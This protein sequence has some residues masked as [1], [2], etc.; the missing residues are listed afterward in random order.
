MKKQKRDWQEKAFETVDKSYTYFSTTNKTPIINVVA[1]VGSGKTDVASNAFY[2]FI[3]NNLDNNTLQIFICPR[4][5]LCN[6]QTESIKKY[7]AEYK[8]TTTPTNDNIAL[9]DFIEMHCE[10]KNKPAKLD[11]LNYKHLI[12]VY[13]DDSFWEQSLDIN[14]WIKTRFELRNFKEA[15]Y[16]LGY[17]NFDEAHNY[18]N[19]IDKIYNSNNYSTVYSSNKSKCLDKKYNTIED[20]GFAGIMLT[21]GTPAEYQ[22]NLIKNKFKFDNI[23]NCECS[24]KEAFEKRY[25]VKPTINLVKC[26]RDSSLP[27]A[28]LEILNREKELC[29]KTKFPVRILNCMKG[30][31]EINRLSKIIDIE[32]KIGKEFHLINLHSDKTALDDENSIIEQKPSIDNIEKSQEEVLEELYKIDNNTS[33]LNDNLPIIVQ[34]V[35]M[36]SE[37]INIR[38]FNS[39]ILSSNQPVKVTQQIGRAIR[40]YE[41]NGMSKIDNNHANIYVMFD[42]LDDVYEL[43]KNLEKENTLTGDCFNW[44]SVSEANP[45]SGKAEVETEI[46]EMA[47][48]NW[49]DLEKIEIQVISDDNNFKTNIA[50]TNKIKENIKINITEC[51]NQCTISRIVNKHF[52]NDFN[53]KII[54][55]R[56][57]IDPECNTLDRFENFN[58]L[59]EHLNKIS[60]FLLNNDRYK[61]IYDNSKNINLLKSISNYLKSNENLSE[62]I[63]E[64][65]DKT[66]LD[67]IIYF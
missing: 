26:N 62:F 52:N 33:K 2:K 21:T 8:I 14:K 17:I 45:K 59:K 64:N 61:E 54:E 50:N 58:F 27:S 35:A 3:T 23:F 49:N 10:S 40:H 11:P 18:K 55:I 16:K 39:V 56:K 7:L 1:A 38:S 32:S 20:F 19:H 44:E 63:I 60:N 36:I 31:D 42:N 30:I 29:K 13:C 65:F 4:I 46:A 43:F 41:Y 66:E 57:L 28:F 12:L 6:A 47:S 5:T 51:R 9:V 15:G 53:N 25:I 37:G 24:Y 22:K 48:Y 34:Q 67:E